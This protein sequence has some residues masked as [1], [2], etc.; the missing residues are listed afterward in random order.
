[1][2]FRVT[3][4]T[5]DGESLVAI[6]VGPETLGSLKLRGNKKQRLHNLIKML[7]EE[8]GAEELLEEFKC[9]K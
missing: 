2:I 5:G 6:Q 3:A 9:E 4:V 7:L 8:A 1:M